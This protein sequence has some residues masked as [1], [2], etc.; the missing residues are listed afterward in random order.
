[1]K[2]CN[3]CSHPVSL[4][5]PEGDNR[6]RYVCTNCHSVHYINPKVVTGC[7]VHSSNKVL[8]CK[9]AIS[10]REGLWTLPAGFMELG[11]TSEEGASRETYEEAC[12]RVKILGLYTLFDL[13]HISQIYLFY[14]SELENDAFAP[15][16]ES[17]EV[18]L[19]EEQDIPWSDLAFPVV[20]RP[21]QPYFEDR[22]KGYYN[23]RTET[24]IPNKI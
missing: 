9:R 23:F 16:T 17:L 8:L 15:G 21:L 11:E 10:P 2:F 6:E 14:R 24:I 22:K 1:M 19:F 4:L 12:A 20:E 3:V 18:R 7:L 5:I 13:P